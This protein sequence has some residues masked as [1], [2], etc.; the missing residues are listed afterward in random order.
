MDNQTDKS[1]NLLFCCRDAAAFSGLYPLLAQHFTLTICNN[2]S[3]HL[4]LEKLCCYNIAIIEVASNNDLMLSLFKELEFRFPHIIIILINGQPDQQFLTT[5][6]KMGVKD[7]F[8]DP[9]DNNLLYERIIS[10]FSNYQNKEQR[11]HP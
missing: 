9:V 8:P 1:L 3:A 5:A 6:F 11:R 4:A 2:L 10:F 7:Y